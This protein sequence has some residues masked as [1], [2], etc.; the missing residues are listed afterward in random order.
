MILY[1]LK[2]SCP[3]WYKSSR[4]HSFKK[5]A[6]IISNFLS[7]CTSLCV[8][9]EHLGKLFWVLGVYGDSLGKDWSFVSSQQLLA[10][11]PRKAVQFWEEQTQPRKG[12][13][14]YFALGVV[15]RGLAGLIYGS[16]ECWSWLPKKVLLSLGLLR[17]ATTSVRACPLPKHTHLSS[18]SASWAQA[19]LQLFRPRSGRHRLTSELPQE[20]H[21]LDRGSYIT[22]PSSTDSWPFNQ[23]QFWLIAVLLNIHFWYIPHLVYG[24]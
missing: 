6:K 21:P 16:V 9:L 4:I 3:R 5:I 20:Y 13:I 12:V 8:V 24:I 1:F 7:E 19:H 2:Q 11:S 10:P 23:P 17:Q 15:T 22:L 14:V 18:P